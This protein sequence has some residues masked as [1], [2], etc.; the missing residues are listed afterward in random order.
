VPAPAE[1]PKPQEETPEEKA[2]ADREMWIGIIGTIVL[3]AVVVILA[4]VSDSSGD[5]SADH[6]ANNT[7]DSIA[8]MLEA[9][10]LDDA[11]LDGNVSGR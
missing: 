4:S 2:R 6:Y 1:L 8:N 10:A 5:T 11:Q 3:I 7:I 9:D